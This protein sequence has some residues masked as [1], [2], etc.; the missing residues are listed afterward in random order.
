MDGTQNVT[1]YV[2]GLAESST[3]LALDGTT[4][5][6]KQTIDYDAFRRA[7]TSTSPL[8]AANLTTTT[9]YN[10]QGQATSVT[11]PGTGNH[12]YSVGTSSGARWSRDGTPLQIVRPDGHRFRH[13]HHRP[14]VH[15][16]R[17]H[18]H[19]DRADDISIRHDRRHR[20]SHHHLD[21]QAPVG[22]RASGES[23][24]RYLHWS[25][26][27]SFDPKSI[28]P[29]AVPFTTSRSSR[30]RMEVACRIE[31]SV[32]VTVAIGLSGLVSAR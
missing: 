23:H 25:S 22:G 4:V 14:K 12:T 29:N 21:P 30:T 18:G 20:R 8:G 1:R 11:L 28:V 26:A 17:R 3:D 16:Q 5:L 6:G 13:R 32:S 9:A 31:P 27:I 10:D 15:L 19:P 2:D 24:G 7:T